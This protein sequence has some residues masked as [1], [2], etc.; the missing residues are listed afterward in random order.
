MNSWT[1]Y[2]H[3]GL[4][5][6]LI[7]LWDTTLRNQKL[8]KLTFIFSVRLYIKW[9]PFIH[10]LQF[11]WPTLEHVTIQQ[12]ALELQKSPVK[13]I[14]LHLYVNFENQPPTL[15]SQ[16]PSV[17]AYN[18]A[19]EQDK[20]TFSKHSKTY[21][22][23]LH[24]RPFFSASIIFSAPLWKSSLT[25]RSAA[26]WH[27]WLQAAAVQQEISSERKRPLQLPLSS[28]SAVKRTSVVSSSLRLLFLLFC[29][30]GRRSL[31]SP[32]VGRKWI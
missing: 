30:G 18:P 3:H 19:M 22:V 10:K 7:F 17:Q 8:L 11:L 16:T 15:P 24:M 21:I 4:T 13:R 23:I 26:L 14:K 32:C 29:R 5:H 27:S 2:T 12:T 28:A 25:R 1:P 20:I 6:R 9:K 31:S